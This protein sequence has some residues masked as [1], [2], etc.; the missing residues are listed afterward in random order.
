[1]VAQKGG[2]DATRVFETPG[3][4]TLESV[5][6][7]EFFT[8]F[9]FQHDFI[10]RLGDIADRVKRERWVLGAAGEQAALVAQYDNLPDDLLT[11]YTKDFGAAWQDALGS[12]G[13][14]R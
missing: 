8:Y 7:P 9:G 12:C 5:R 13:C 11:L 3:D 2:P 10:E 1:M 4:P 6:V 14:A